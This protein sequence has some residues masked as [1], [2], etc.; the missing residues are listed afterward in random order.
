MRQAK[1]TKLKSGETFDPVPSGL[2]LKRVDPPPLASLTFL[3][4]WTEKSGYPNYSLVRGIG[5]L[6]TKSQSP[7]IGALQ[8]I[9]PDFKLHALNTANQNNKR[10]YNSRDVKQI[11]PLHEPSLNPS[12]RKEPIRPS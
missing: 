9:K 8:E 4:A 1:V 2:F 5:I 6:N 7:V 10:T 11:R 12:N 3:G